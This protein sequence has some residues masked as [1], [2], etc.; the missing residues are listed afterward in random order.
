M[1]KKNIA[2]LENVAAGFIAQMEGMSM[3][4][5]KARQ[6]YGTSGDKFPTTVWMNTHCTFP[7]NLS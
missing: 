2:L 5:K 7:P 1:F 3:F 4:P 6:I